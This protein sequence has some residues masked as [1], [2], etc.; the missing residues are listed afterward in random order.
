VKL[1][2]S[3]YLFVAILLTQFI[4]AYFFSKSKNNC[5][6][7]FSALA[8]CISIYLFGYLMIINNSNL[9]ELIF[10]NQVQYLGLPFISVLWLTVALL[11][12]KTVYTLS[13]RTVVLLFLVPVITFFMRLT[14]PWHHLFYKNWQLKQFWEN[15]F[16]SMER[17][18]W[19]Y[20][21]IS[22]TVLCLFLTIIIYCLGYWKK[23]AG[24]TRP[25]FLVFLFA[26]I[27]PFIG[28]MLIIFVFPKWSFDYT[29]LLVP[30]SMFIISFG[31]IKYDFLEIKTL[32]RETIFENSPVG[33]MILESG[34]RLID[35]NKSAKDFFNA[36]NI[37]LDYYPIKDL[38]K[39]EPALLEIFKSETTQEFRVMI[40][41][42]ERF[43][44]ISTVP[45]G[46][47]PL[48]KGT[49]M[50]KSIQDITEKKK[51]KDALAI[52]A[53][54]DSLSGLYNRVAFMKLGQKELSRAK[55]H[56]EQL[57]LLMMDLDS[58]KTINDTFGHA[59]GDEVIRKLGNIITTSFRKTDFAGRLGGDEFVVLLKNTS[60]T[61]AKRIAEKFRETVFKTKVFYKNQEISF[62]VSIGVAAMLDIDNND[63][64]EDILKQADEALYQAKAQGRNCV[65]ASS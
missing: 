5:R 4:T 10:W 52:L 6:K 49:R 22:Y 61:E 25:Q 2:L 47:N 3:F 56:N 20:V 14:N 59:A 45:L 38:F 19:Y 11:Y 17:G 31:I 9:Q 51:V 42:K 39:T 24:Y 40:D 64:I 16:L 54:L 15:S 21:N 43:F 32:A 41:G 63:N 37:S 18:Y 30:I 60:L 1:L 23:Q 34:L 7:A 57:S 13:K 58:F 28:I 46:S 27:L 53:T 26:S 50:L 33:M 44:E 65:V 12:T 35:Y 62:T 36:L 8:L 29:A 48:G 55:K